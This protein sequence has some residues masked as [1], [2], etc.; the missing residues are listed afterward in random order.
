MSTICPAT[1][2]PSLSS[3]PSDTPFR[4]FTMLD[5]AADAVMLG[6]ALSALAESFARRRPM[7]L[8]ETSRV[9]ILILI[10]HFDRELV[11]AATLLAGLGIAPDDPGRLHALETELRSTSSV[12]PEGPAHRIAIAHLRHFRER[13]I[14]AVSATIET[15]PIPLDGMLSLEAS[16][17]VTTTFCLRPPDPIDAAL[18]RQL[19][20]G[21]EHVSATAVE[22][23]SDP[24]QDRADWFTLQQVAAAC[25]QRTR[26]GGIELPRHKEAGFKRSWSRLVR[27]YREGGPLLRDYPALHDGDHVDDWVRGQWPG[28]TR[29][30]PHHLQFDTWIHRDWLQ[31]LRDLN[32]R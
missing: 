31:R 20:T 1:A 17:M 18:L 13:M 5:A 21:L 8:R 16:T 26:L 3:V 28:Y 32:Q 4:L 2:P 12:G 11:T 23:F 6:S 9:E 24:R 22:L 19:R 30:L 14:D 25:E 27:S 10:Q 29:R 15:A 7:D